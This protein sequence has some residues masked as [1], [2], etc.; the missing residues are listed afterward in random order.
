MADREEAGLRALDSDHLKSFYRNYYRPANTI[1]SIS[2]DVDADATLRLVESLYGN[3]PGGEPVRDRGPVEPDR[4]GFRYR[5]L[6]GDVGQSQLLIG[7]RTP[8][9]M[10]PDT[11][12]LDFL[13]SILGDGRASRLYRSVRERRL[14]AYV[15]SGNHTPTELGIFVIHAE[16]NPETAVD[17]LGA[18]WAEVGELAK[19]N[20]S[21][22][23]IERVR[24]MFEAH[25]A[26]RLETAQGRAT[27]LASWEAMGGWKIGEEY[28]SSFL[29]TTSSDV[30]RVAGQYLTRD[31]A[32]ALV[33][34]PA[35]A[36]V[37][38]ADAAEMERLLESRAPDPPDRSVT[39]LRIR[40]NAKGAVELERE[41][42][43]VFVFRSPAGIPILVRRKRGSPIAHIA[44]HAIGGAVRDPTERAGLT[45]IAARTM[46][47]GTTSLAANEIAQAT[48]SLGATLG[49][50][51]G[52]ESFGWSMSVPTQRFES[53]VAL[54]SDVISNPVFA[55]ESVET[56]RRVAL[57]NLA[58]IRDDMMRYPIRLLAAAAFQS[59]PYGVPP[60]GTEE[61]LAAI[62]ADD[63]RAWHSSTVLRS[64]M[65]IGIVAD[66]EPIEAAQI[67]AGS[68]SS[69]GPS[70]VVEIPSPEW[71]HAPRS[72]SESRDKA[73]TALA[74]AFPGPAR[75]DD[76]RW[77]AHLLST[78]ASG[79]GGR[80]FDELRDKRS[81]AYTVHLSAQ[82]MRAGGMFIAYIATSPEKEDEARAA[83]LSEFERLRAYPVTADELTR[84][85]EYIIGS[86]A[87]SRE[88][89]ASL[90]G[91]MLDAW[92]FGKGLA[93]LNEYDAHVEEVTAADIQ[94][95]AE[96]SFRKEMLVEAVVR[97]V[98]RTV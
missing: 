39:P 80:L 8:A 49:A 82:D 38:A 73:Q 26:R 75:G 36:P 95:I 31:R 59:H 77:A 44:A 32:A 68:L 51:A 10:H 13:A 62:S 29:A 52:L 25:Y 87:I 18:I 98:P 54:F 97:G 6:S 64:S 41:E 67:A 79:L 30:R 45:L 40:S 19:T 11:P 48:E 9:A 81:L 74:L 92:L 53:A 5:E 2:G 27:Y 4:T 83:L 35:A 24:S 85:K 43:G 94:R 56:E 57:S 33:Y 96:E 84:A 90:L 3:L 15:S 21:E 76:R 58:L 65:A 28:R 89:G 20:V 14:A 34:R 1:L 63:L 72:V 47:K 60:S 69:L 70:N 22:T 93:D 55:A 91:E 12:K 46:L 37:V 86:H 7:W 71:T 61:S 42:S 23:E 16:A 66:I 50:N 78:V 88:S 17:A